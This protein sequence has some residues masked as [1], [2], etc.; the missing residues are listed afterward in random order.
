M[1]FSFAISTGTCNSIP[2]HCSFINSSYGGIKNANITKFMRDM[3]S[4]FDPL[5]PVEDNSHN[6]TN[7][8]NIK[9][10]GHENV[11]HVNLL[12]HPKIN[13]KMNSDGTCMVS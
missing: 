6:P 3:N 2:T 5:T 12:G 8:V 10:S 4:T 13:I 1:D 7:Y 11:C 9:I